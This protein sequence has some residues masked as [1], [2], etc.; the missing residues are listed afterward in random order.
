MGYLLSKNEILSGSAVSVG[1]SV[2]KQVISNVMRVSAQDSLH[3]KFNVVVS[4]S[5]VAVG[6]NVILQHFDGLG[7]VDVDGTNYKISIP[8][9][10]S[11][12]ASNYL[13]INLD[14]SKV[15]NNYIIYPSCRLVI[16]TGAGDSCKIDSIYK[17][18]RSS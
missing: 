4:A 1:A 12:A 15:G 11:A 6:I 16:T 17:T 14:P 2:T 13:E 9:A 3:C 7:W 18:I 8:N 10:I 5:T